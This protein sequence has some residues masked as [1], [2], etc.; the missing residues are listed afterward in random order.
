MPTLA[1][2][3]VGCLG[4]YNLGTGLGGFRCHPLGPN[5]TSPTSLTRPEKATASA[6]VKA[7]FLAC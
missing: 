7:A 4:P 5:A 1:Y 2:A 3:G 6:F